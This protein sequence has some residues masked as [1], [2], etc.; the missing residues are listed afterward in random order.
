MTE[1]ELIQIDVEQTIASK[2]GDRARLVPKFVTNWVRRTICEDELNEMLRLFYPKRGA[3]FCETALEHLDVKI[4][5]ENED[6]LPPTDD[7]RVIFVCNHPLGGLDGIALIALLTRKYGSGVKF[8]V[9]DMLMAIDPIKDVFLPINKHGRQSRDAIQMINSTLEGPDPVVIFPAGLVS[10]KSSKGVI[11]DLEWHKMFVAKALQYHRDIVPLFF[12]G[13]N[14]PFFYNFAQWR[15]RLG[16]KLNIEM[17]Y[18]P[19]EV[20]R[21]RGKSFVIKV[22][23]RVSWSALRNADQAVIAAMVREMAYAL[24]QPSNQPKS[25]QL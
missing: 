19:R 9:N 20:I 18:L 5:V 23:Q 12:S 7:R 8:V 13:H 24:D 11:M 17:V 15:K 3:E 22:G 21:A 4:S 2:L 1:P 6:K 16:I 14:S 10:R 25:T